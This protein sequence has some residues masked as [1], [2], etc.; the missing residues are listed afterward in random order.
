M[1]RDKCQRGRMSCQILLLA[2]W[3][4]DDDRRAVA[5]EG[6]CVPALVH[7]RAVVALHVQPDVPCKWTVGVVIHLRPSPQDEQRFT[8][9]GAVANVPHDPVLRAAL[10][11]PRVNGRAGDE[12]SP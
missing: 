2:A 9:P 6:N 10:R 1:L 5:L 7:I 11:W 4:T 12:L 8:G 3:L